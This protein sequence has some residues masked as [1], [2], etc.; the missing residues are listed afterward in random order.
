MTLEPR[1]QLV[2]QAYDVDEVCVALTEVSAILR[3]A[4]FD[5]HDPVVQYVCRALDILGYYQWEEDDEDEDC[6]ESDD[7]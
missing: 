2:L 1:P 3:D 7:E 6:G 4:G 5:E